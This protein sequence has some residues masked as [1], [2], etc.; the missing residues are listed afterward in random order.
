MI[1]RPNN[2]TLFRA[3]SV[4]KHMISPL[5]S[6]G[7]LLWMEKA[8]TW[9]R[10]IGRISIRSILC[11]TLIYDTFKRVHEFA[12]CKEGTVMMV[13]SLRRIDH[14]RQQAGTNPR[15]GSGKHPRREGNVQVTG[16]TCPGRRRPCRGDDVVDKGAVLAVYG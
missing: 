6:R 10:A 13:A 3:P 5:R 12:A 7:Y 9:R 11:D 4:E 8:S 1:L 16:K 14:S 15:E 2:F